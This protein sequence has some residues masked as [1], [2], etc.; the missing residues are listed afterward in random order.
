LLLR[1][2][3][4]RSLFCCSPLSLNNFPSALSRIGPGLGSF[5]ETTERQAERQTEDREHQLARRLRRT[6]LSLGIRR[7]RSSKWYKDL[8]GFLAW[9]HLEISHIKAVPNCQCID[10]TYRTLPSLL[11]PMPSLKHPIFPLKVP[12]PRTGILS[13][14]LRCSVRLRQDYSRRVVRT[15]SPGCLYFC[16]VQ[17]SIMQQTSVCGPIAV[18][19]QT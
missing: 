15:S 7:W 14:T 6:S 1:A 19:Y 4:S 5:A 17:T 8:E 12:S 10:R 9:L 16:I 18:P 3:C 2:V 11:T 13:A